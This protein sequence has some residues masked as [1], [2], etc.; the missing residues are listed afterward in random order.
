MPPPAPP[1]G[2]PTP[3]FSLTLEPGT[4]N[5]EMVLVV[6][7]AGTAAS[8]WIIQTGTGAA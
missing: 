8:P 5:F 7:G 2:I 1:P 4:A 3:P 6:S